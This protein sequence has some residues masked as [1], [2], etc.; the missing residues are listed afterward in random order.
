MTEKR[1]KWLKQRLKEADYCDLGKYGELGENW[2]IL[3]DV[4]ELIEERT[5]ATESR[6]EGIE[7]VIDLIRNHQPSG[8]PFV[9]RVE[10]FRKPLIE[11]AERLKEQG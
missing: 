8:T 3:Y 7:A 4:E 5:V 9:D 10:H 6:K 1:I 2:D 11:E